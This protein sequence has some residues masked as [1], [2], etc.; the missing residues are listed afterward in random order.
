MNSADILCADD[1]CPRKSHFDQRWIYGRLSIQEILRR[2][3]EFGL[4][5][6]GDGGQAAGDEAMT[7]ASENEVILPDGNV[8]ESAVN[9]AALADLIVTVLRGEDAPWGRPRDAKA[10]NVPW[11]SGAFLNGQQTSLHRIVLA[12][13]WNEERALHERR[14]WF[15]LGECCIYEM[16]LVQ[17]VFIVGSNRGGKFQSPWSKANQHPLN[18][19]IRFKRRDGE[20][21]EGGWKQ[22][23]REDLELSKDEWLGVMQDDGVLETSYFQETIKVPIPEVRRKIVKLAEKKLGKVA[24]M[25]SV[26]EPCPTQC[27]YP[28]PSC[29][30]QDVCWTFQKSPSE[31]TGFIRIG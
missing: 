21:F 10:G 25:D 14:S 6:D 26:P 15:S 12:A 7:L 22:V 9:C 17:H 29:P 2:S 3:V 19:G 31:S 16:P 30:Y 5:F 18:R 28:L 11:E 24:A 20:K 8:Y 23:Y 13:Q 27:V 1:R 4:E